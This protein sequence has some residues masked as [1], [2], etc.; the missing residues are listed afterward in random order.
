MMTRCPMH[1]VTGLAA[2]AWGASAALG[3]EPR[4]WNF[5]L[6]TTGNDVHWVSPTAVD[7]TRPEYDAVYDITR[8][9]VRVRYGP[10]DLGP[11]DITGQIPPEQRHGE[12]TA[13]GP[14][15]MVIF[16][17]RVVYP[18]PPESPG[19][20]ANVRISLDA[21]GF[22][23]IDLTDVFL[24]DIRIDL[25]PPFGVQTVRL[26]SVRLVGVTTVTPVPAGDVNRDGNVDQADLGILLGAWGTCPGDPGYDPRANLAPENPC[27]DQAD[28]GILLAGWGS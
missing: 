21:D 13:A 12:G 5:D 4:T 19:F 20:A 14:P 27:I 11:F 25:G 16:D 9:E 7:N 10:F 2:L 17:D 8:L 26:T 15:P 22:G 28:L 23:H 1:A 3:G 18:P 6:T 24:G